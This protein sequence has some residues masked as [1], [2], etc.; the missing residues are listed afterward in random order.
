MIAITNDLLDPQ[1]VS[2]PYSY[3]KQIRQEDP[4]YW[5]DR[6]KGWIITK[7]DDVYALLQD[8]RISADRI[9]KQVMDKMPTE[10][11]YVAEV[12]KKW[13]PLTDPPNHTRIR[14]V[15]QKAFS[16]RVIGAMRDTIQNI[17][18]Q[19]IDEIEKRERIDIV[20]DY[21]FSIPS[22][23]LSA[24]M[25]LPSEDFDK[26]KTWTHDLNT[27]VF[28]DLSVKDRHM[29]AFLAVKEM[30]AYFE[31]KFEERK[32]NPGTDLISSLIEA[33]EGGILSPEELIAQSILLFQAGHETTTGMIANSLL[34]LL[35]NPDQMKLLKENPSLINTAVEEFV[36]YDGAAK[37]VVRVAT[38]DIEIRNKVIKKGERLLI[39]N[40]SANR[41]EEKFENPD[42][43]DITR[44]PNPHLGFGHGAHYCL[45]NQLARLEVRIAVSTFLQR[46]NHLELAHDQLSWES[47][48]VGRLLKSLD[49]YI[50]I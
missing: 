7:Y 48:M 25:G 33:N 41:D 45:G 28:I 26:I 32:R 50:K 23:V 39:V 37:S 3:F 9:S 31:E 19:A 12:M 8:P 2:D 34:A 46:I 1:A 21:A 27:L 10:G 20:S 36:R 18:N 4:V 29:K 40:A 11:K 5:N 6:W 17:V 43:L 38:E 35:K 16:P 15:L 22:N 42:Q 30:S 44:D 49:V 47:T 24:M 14:K 13:M